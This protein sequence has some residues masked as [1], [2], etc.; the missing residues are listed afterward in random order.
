MV[1]VMAEPPITRE[2]AYGVRPGNLPIKHVV[3]HD[4]EYPVGDTSAESVAAFFAGAT[5]R[6][7]AHYIEDSDSEQ[8]CVAEDHIAAHAPPNTG[9]VG[10]EQDGY[11]HFTVEDWTRPGSQATIR[12]TAA[13]VADICDRHDVPKRWV[14]VDDLRAGG[15]GIT[16]HLNKSLAFGQSDHTDPGPN[17]PVH[18]FMS[19]VLGVAPT[20]TDGHTPSPQEDE[21]VQLIQ[22]ADAP[23]KV[24]RDK[25]YL[26]S[27]MLRAY[28]GTPKLVNELKFVGVPGPTPIP[29][30]WFD[31]LVDAEALKK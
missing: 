9:S 27:G 20:T 8:H 25:V 21:L 5:A 2:A 15:H 11:A 1:R 29:G 31:L 19:L 23:T 26:S 17:Y 14:T 6:G 12:R 4:E 3:I 16:S 10:L 7:S 28:V 24:E 18:W 30:D 13:R 22:N